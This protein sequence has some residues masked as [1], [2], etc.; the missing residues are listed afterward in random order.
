MDHETSATT[1]IVGML[2]DQHTEIRRLM[3][4]VG[5]SPGADREEAFEPLLRLLAV[6]ET[7]EEEIVYPAI[8]HADDAA[9]AIVAARRHEED[10]AKKVL[11]EL[12][13]MDA[14]SAEF[15]DR[16][17]ELSVAVEEHAAAEERE[18]FPYLAARHDVGE[19]ESMGKA[20]AAAEMFA[21]TH[22]HAMAPEGAVANMVVG[23]FV[24]VVDRV[25]DA[26]RDA[27]R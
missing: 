8:E 3:Y 18:V 20:F 7:A 4:T 26:I 16:F 2:R 10:A 21:P 14:G 24:A 23:P 12:E 17:V 22:A 19:R 6:H 13:G 15:A 1:D 27:R 9:A 5:Q 11:A 25:R